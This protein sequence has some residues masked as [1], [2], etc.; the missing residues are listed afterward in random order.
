MKKFRPDIYIE[1][2]DDFYFII[3][4]V[5]SNLKTS[6]FIVFFLNFVNY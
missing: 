1:F 5:N 3:I 6:I 4:S 2:N